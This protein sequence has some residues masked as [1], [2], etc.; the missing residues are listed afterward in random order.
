MTRSLAI[1][2]AAL[3]ATA[4]WSAAA[5][6]SL[7][8]H[9]AFYSIKL[10]SADQGSNIS[11]AKGVMR[12]EW[13]Q[14]CEGWAVSQRMLLN[15]E[16]SIGAAVS[17]EVHFSSFESTD[18]SE[19]NFTS[20][21]VT[22]GEVTDEYRGRASRAEPGAEVEASYSVP[23]G[24][25]RLM[26][27]NTV[28]P[29]EHTRQLLAAAD[30]GESR[31]SLPFFDG[32]RPQDSPFEANALILGEAR[33]A[34]EGTGAGLGPITER[35]WWSVRVAFFPGG[36]NDPEPDFELAA[37]FQDNGVVRAYQFDYGDFI[38]EAELVRIEAHEVPA[39]Q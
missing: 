33:A 17:T 4:S 10:R 39:C 18:S 5:A 16:A 2:S 36:S 9:Q 30:S 28:F 29:M 1:V 20:R 7:A 34:S 25:S 11:S 6:T 8:P 21:T 27:A 12:Q 13:N 15:L 3:L 31:L 38:L 35:R 32:P 19:Y 26:P 22:N 23:V 14:S 37:D 24:E